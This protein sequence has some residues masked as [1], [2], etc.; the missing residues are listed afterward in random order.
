MAKM[1]N[2]YLAAEFKGYSAQILCFP[3]NALFFINHQNPNFFTTTMNSYHFNIHLVHFM[4]KCMFTTQQVSYGVEGTEIKYTRDV[5]TPRVKTGAISTLANLGKWGRY[6]VKNKWCYFSF[7]TVV[8][9]LDIMP[10]I[11]PNSF[12]SPKN[13]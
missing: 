9:A 7:D 1:N 8:A 2:F 13:H 5:T 6:K 3:V 11:W 4:M 12:G 10:G